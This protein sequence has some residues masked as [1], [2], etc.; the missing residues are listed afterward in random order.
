MKK[1]NSRRGMT[2]VELLVV[3]A[4]IGM[5]VALL[6]PAVQ[7]ARESARRTSCTN[8]LKQLGLALQTHHDTFNRLPPGA[9]VDSDSDFTSFKASNCGVY[10]P[11]GFSWMVYL[12]PYV[13]QN[14]LLSS[15]EFGEGAGYGVPNN[16]GLLHQQ[17]FQAFICPSS[18]QPRW[19]KWWVHGNA[20]GD[21]FAYTMAANYVGVA[22]AA[23]SL[24]NP[25]ADNEVV[26]ETGL[27]M[28]LNGGMISG[29]GVLF[30][31][32]KIRFA[33]VT[34]G[35]SNVLAISEH[36]DFLRLD[37][38]EKYDFRAS[39]PYGWQLG[40]W[41]GSGA[42]PNYGSPKNWSS[43]DTRTFNTTTIRYAINKK[44][45]WPSTSRGIDGETSVGNCELGVCTNSS[46][47]V[48]LNSAHPGGVL[49]AKLD[50]SVVFLSQHMSLANLARLALRADG[51]AVAE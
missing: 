26:F 4:I 20:N 19:A 2:L 16:G 22:G 5:L 18:P 11:W 31:L 32:S 51:E 34:D 9:A 10:C 47:N 30:P 14:N 38:G 36:A 46:H 7:A 33:N 12:L 49:A 29:G 15:M 40:A 35:T 44:T 42:P 45:G 39:Q 24:I 6:L 3:I 41:T 48:P 37:T 8:K 13:E 21:P 50:G 17:Q 1:F 27:P 25:T 43:L 23:K 28:V